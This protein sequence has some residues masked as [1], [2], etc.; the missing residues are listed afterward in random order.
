MKVPPIETVFAKLYG[1]PCWNVTKGLGSFLTFEFGKPRLEIREPRKPKPDASPAVK[2]AMARR[3]INVRGEW[4]LWIYCC[5]WGVF[6]GDQL[7][8]DCSRTRRINRAAALLDGQKLMNVEII[9]R[10]C[11]TVFEFD[12]GG[13]LETKPYNRTDEQWMLFDPS[14]KVLTLRADKKYS[15]TPSDPCD[16]DENWKFITSK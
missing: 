11:R 12:L 16:T 13:I 8:G 4:H 14:G 15:Y 3:R 1:K 7:I 2:R 9:P 10:G 5:D 6:D